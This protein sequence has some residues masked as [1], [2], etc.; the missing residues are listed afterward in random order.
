MGAQLATNCLCDEPA[1]S[2]VGAEPDQLDT[3]ANLVLHWEHHE[4]SLRSSS[5]GG[6]SERQVTTKDRAPGAG[7]RLRADSPSQTFHAEV[8][9]AAA[10]FAAAFPGGECAS[11]R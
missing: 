1:G 10:A 11:E 8:G 3:E 4:P 5:E 2:Q 9:E 6:R 7:A